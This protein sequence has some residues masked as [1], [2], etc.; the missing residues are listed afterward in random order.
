M[1]HR[2]PAAPAAGAGVLA[3]AFILA[4]CAHHWHGAGIAPQSRAAAQTEPTPT[5]ASITDVVRPT[6]ASINDVIVQPTATATP[7]QTP[8]PTP[9]PAVQT[10]RPTT[11]DV[12]PR[13]PSSLEA[14]DAMLDSETGIFGVMVLDTDGDLRYSRNADTPFITASLYK[15][16]L[17]ADILGRVERGEITMDQELF[18]APAYFP[19]DPSIPDGGY[20]WD[21]METTITVQEALWSTIC[22][23]SNVSA[24]ALLDLTTTEDL[25][26]LAQELGLQDTLFNRQLTQLPDWKQAATESPMPEQFSQAVSLIETEALNWTVNLTT[27]AN[28]ARFLQM[29]LDG[30][31]VSGVVSNQLLELLFDQQIIDRIPA[32]LPDDVQV[33]HKTGNLIG[34][35]H[36]VGV[37]MTEEGPLILVAM[38]EGVPDEKHATQV[39]QT[40]AAVVFRD[41][42]DPSAFA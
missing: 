6:V 22:V 39:I 23:S 24:L 27:P 17:V 26:G 21:D 7:A 42:G 11:L 16:L 4:L 12:P 2:R 37:I 3:L 40:I 14:L 8:T 20:T 32:L 5:V 34:I 19:Y 30:E 31:V 10:E 13:I 28:M 33:A 36:D 35:V 38:S 15:L 9:T 41:L 18:L 25:N 1:A 29:L